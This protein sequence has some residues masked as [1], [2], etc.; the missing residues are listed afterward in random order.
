MRIIQLIDSLEAGG[1]ERMAVNIANGL[2][3]KV[4]FS[5]LVTTRLE[6]DLK[7]ALKTEVGYKF[8]HKNQTFDI[9]ALLIFR[10]YIKRNKVEV[11]HAHGSSYF[12]SVLIKIIYP[13][14]KLFWHDHN[15]N[16]VLNGKSNFFISIFSVFFKG[17]FTV[18]EDLES[19]AK[20]KLFCKKN[21]FI[22]N[23]AVE[24][25]NEKPTTFLKGTSGK[26]MVCLAN[27]REPKNH[28]TLISAFFESKAINED[29]TL[30][31]IGKDN[32]DEYSKALKIFIAENNLENYVFMYGSCNDIGLVLQQATIGVLAST[33]EG[34]PVTLLEYGLA[35]LS[36]L[37]TNVGYCKSLLSSAENGLLFNP[38]NKI[39][40]INKMNYLFQNQFFIVNS[41]ENFNKFVTANYS[42]SIILSKMIEFYK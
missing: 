19:W 22:P 24:N 40:L 42:E 9:K 29:W 37:S 36:V 41:A 2:V 15:G 10:N 18:N 25:K 35:K 6:G 14:V 20:K 3:S 33:Y 4:A 27:L 30:H 23:F 5:G 21:Q 34:F 28:I 11:I 32:A 17:V 31:L 13:K 8:L 38:N 26:R 12:F 1:A 16:R 7:T 39:E